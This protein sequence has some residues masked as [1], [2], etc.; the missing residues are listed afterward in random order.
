MNTIVQK[1]LKNVDPI[2]LNSMMDSF[3]AGCL[4]YDLYELGIKFNTIPTKDL[5][6][7]QQI[8]NNPRLTSEELGQVALEIP[9]TQE[10]G[11]GKST[12]TGAN[13]ITPDST[14]T[15]N[16][17]NE[18]QNVQGIDRFV[19]Y[20]F[21]FDNDCPECKNSTSIT[22]SQPYDSWYSQYVG[23]ESVYQSTAPTK[24]YINNGTTEF[25]K[26]GISEFFT[27]VV[28]GNYDFINNDLIK[29]LGD[30]L[31]KGGNV[32]ID[33]QGSAS[34][35][36]SEGYNQKL[37]KRRIDSVK[38][39]LKTKQDVNGVS[40]NDYITNNKIKITE[41]PRGEEISIPKTNTNTGDTQT[42]VSTN[43]TQGILSSPI[44]C[45]S[46]VQEK[47]GN[48]FK[49]TTNA[50][51]YS[52]PAMACRRVIIK[53]ITAQQPPEKTPPKDVGG[54]SQTTDTTTVNVSNVN[55][56]VSDTIKPTPNTTIE[57]K[58]KDGISK[59]VLRHLFSECDYF[60]VIKESDPMVYQSI[61]DKI[62][63]FNPAFHSM[64]P[65]GLNSRLTF[66]NQCVRPGQTIPIIGADGRPKYNDALNTSFGAPP[67][68]VLR[69]GDFYHSK[70]VPNSLS[71]SYDD[72]KYDL[73]PEG[74][75]V[76]PMIVKVSLGFD[77]IGGHGLKEPVEEL[78]NALSF[79]FYANTEIYDERATATEDVSERDKYVV[80]KI[81]SNQPPVKIN[82]VQNQIPKR[83]GS[84]IGNII[85][86]TEIDYTGSLNNFWKKTIE[87]IDSVIDTTNTLVKT[88]NIGIAYSLFN[89]RD[90]ILGTFNEYGTQET[91][92]IYGKPKNIEEKL[93]E[94]YKKVLDDISS[95]NN[96][97]SFMN[98]IE[99]NSNN[100]T[101]KDIREI[102][103]RLKTYVSTMKDSFITNV[104]NNVNN[105]IT[106][107]QDY[108]QYVRQ[109]NLI[110]TE[111]DG[112]MNSNNIPN[113]Y[114]LSGDNLNLITNVYTT[115]KNKHIEFFDN[116]N[117][118]IKGINKPSGIQFYGLNLKPNDN[119]I[120]IYD[121]KTSTFKDVGFSEDSGL[122]TED[123]NL[124]DFA[125]KV[126]SNPADNRFYQ[127]MAQVFYSE[128]LRNELK[129]YL[130]DSTIY[131]DKPKVEIAIN[132]AINYWVERNRYTKYCNTRFSDEI[133]KTQEYT[134]LVQ[135]PIDDNTK[136]VVDYTFTTEGTQDQKTRINNIYSTNNI[137][138]KTNTFDG[139]IKFN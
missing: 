25:S 54:G 52:I 90:Y 5:F 132:Q 22:A 129:T 50:E 61:K 14:T 111:T 55:T 130:L 127:V 32:T 76:Q 104:S 44:N 100:I 65:E 70:I 49:T 67:I 48:T 35:V 42:V 114:N 119:Q 18:L 40:F 59:K 103:N 116:P 12:A 99:L 138:T 118:I 19:G 46:N 60:E 20:G 11:G 126:A 66:L 135:S 62:K 64:T 124:V 109:F 43:N 47:V 94:L 112:S 108:V 16:T 56:N 79:N 27:Q 88:T 96:S 45:N 17:S 92:S 57:Q 6:T 33:L 74:I 115:I 68:L 29:E 93:D 73:N 89:D 133:K 101:K 72:A 69:V 58:I 87:Y 41:D 120:N 2:K 51:I 134:T 122:P 13:V 82:Q 113:I 7:Y 10:S 37:S 4:K 125:W 81:L 30:I 3:F 128:T 26:D 8:L 110:L 77:F 71:F 34:A 91:I 139:K 39:W 97:N 78:Q 80:E 9:K 105:L 98:Q 123:V 85:S 117:G 121:N 28:K 15:D 75:G 31:S 84:T 53:N 21:Y 107:Q 106:L 23:R 24:V 36:A 136:Y 86:A 102:G 95:N 38:K 137:N 131:S 83:G 63:H 1:Q